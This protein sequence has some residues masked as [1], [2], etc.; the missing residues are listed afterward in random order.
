MKY[1]LSW[2]R[3]FVSLPPDPHTIAATLS[4]AGL[5]VEN[6]SSVGAAIAGLTTGKIQH[7]APHP[8]ANK[9]V[10]TRIDTGNAT[11]Q[12]VTSASNISEGDIVP[13][14]LP[15]ATVASGM[16]LKAATLR[17]VE[18]FGML[19]SETECGVSED[20]AGIWILPPDIPLGID[21]V[22]HA[23]LNDTVFDIGLL[24]NRGDC[25]SIVGLARELAALFEQPFTLPE[26]KVN[27][28][29]LDH[30]YT[31]RCDSTACPLYT[32]H[33]LAH[34][35]S[36]AT[37]PLLIQRRLQLCGLR[38]VSAYVDITN[39]IM[40]ETGQPLHAFD[41]N[42]LPSNALS[43]AST[44]SPLSLITL[45]GQSRHL[46][47][48]HLC[49]FADSEPIAI[50]GVMGLDNTAVTAATSAIFLEAAVF[51][52]M[53]VRRASTALGHRSDSV[54]RF[55]KGLSTALAAYASLRACE[56][57]QT[58]MGATVSNS[59]V[60]YK[61]P[62]H[63]CFKHRNIALDTQQLNGF[64]GTSYTD[65]QILSCLKRLGFTIKDTHVAVPH[66]RLADIEDWPCLAEEVARVLGFD[67]IPSTL[68]AGPAIAEQDDALYTF[69]QSSIDFF[70]A[71]GFS[72]TCTYPMI[73]TEALTHCYA[74]A[75][76]DWNALANPISPSLAVMRPG[77][78][79][80]LLGLIGYHH[81][82]QRP[83]CAFV[84]TGVRV[85][86]SGE[87]TVLAIALSGQCY[88]P[89]YTA[90]QRAIAQDALSFA[91]A[92]L[93]RYLNHHGIAADFS[94]VET[95]E[96]WMHPHCRHAVMLGSQVIG[97]VA[98]VH[99]DVCDTFGITEAV[100]YAELNLDMLL[101]YGKKPPQYRAFSRFPSTRRD[102]ALTVPK[103][104]PYATIEAFIRQHK[105][106]SVTDSG[107]FDMFESEKLGPDVRGIG[108]YLIYQSQTATLS[109]EKVN[110][111]HQHFC[112]RLLD[113]LPVRQR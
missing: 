103:D 48:G 40:L 99:P 108:V 20:A 45:D 76:Q 80:S 98:H 55:E 10:I 96:T 74:T 72:E 51:D 54:A 42:K 34:L 57:F 13:V 23:A 44:T 4:L 43:V 22:A 113:S 1:P 50:A 73:S 38:T 91:K 18:S 61:N 31:I 110:K 37:T 35:S 89:S 68:P 84:E 77:L 64:L 112:K 6:I 85:T 66:W 79:P 52:P 9:L 69:C 97:H 62:S 11:H 25:Q 86:Q 78:L 2:L 71:N 104:V 92:T 16:T 56:L 75:P 24:P 101:S 102:I 106:K 105:H 49:V 5:E 8:D 15:G 95:A 70:V 17:G 58:I 29:T 47:A 87:D 41:A 12:I 83:D 111:V 59:V 60:Q 81:T 19:C 94:D 107:I 3:T 63:P 30:R 14:A 90:S 82:R 28:S 21:F 93:L 27:T 100:F 109:D 7:I 53:A 36:N 65:D 67:S 88:R 39:Y 26:P 32:G 33:F 46:P